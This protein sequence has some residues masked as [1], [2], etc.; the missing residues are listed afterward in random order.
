MTIKAT[1]L[2]STFSLLP[3]IE[4]VYHM[5]ALFGLGSHDYYI[6]AI[7]ENKRHSSWPIK[8]FRKSSEKSRRANGE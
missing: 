3:G 5:E 4:K 8:R 1:R 2:T 6:Y 7:Y